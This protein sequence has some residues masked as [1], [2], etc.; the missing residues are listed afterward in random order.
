[1]QRK[2]DLAKKSV[3]IVVRFGGSGARIAFRCSWRPLGAKS[4]KRRLHDLNSRG[5]AVDTACDA[6]EAKRN[7]ASPTDPASPT[8]RSPTPTDRDARWR[9][10]LAVGRKMIRSSRWGWDDGTRLRG[11]RDAMPQRRHLLLQEATASVNTF[12]RGRDFA[13]EIHRLPEER[14]QLVFRVRREI[15]EGVYDTEDKLELALERMID[16]VIDQ[17]LED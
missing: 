8:G 16:H 14:R 1:M 13:T 6:V 5:H 10:R 11:G 9:F 3:R 4:V 7:D 2:E 12:G 17:D 15:A